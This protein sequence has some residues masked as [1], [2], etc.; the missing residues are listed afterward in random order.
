MANKEKHSVRNGIIATVVGG[1]ILW[2]V[3]PLQQLFAKLLIKVWDSAQWLWDAFLSN[4]NIPGW[5]ILIACLLALPTILKFFLQIFKD[6][7]PHFKYVNDYIN[8]VNWEWKWIGGQISNLWCFCPSCEGRLVYE[9]FE[10]FEETYVNKT[11]FL[12]ENCGHSTKTTI[13]GTYPQAIGSIEREIE[14]RIR[15]DEY[16]KIF[17]SRAAIKLNSSN[18]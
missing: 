5:L 14:R 17:E 12:C 1:I 3:E 10:V 16:K 18:Q 15:T 9:Q 7:E 8:N 11:N 13:L 6:E 2:L 4:Y